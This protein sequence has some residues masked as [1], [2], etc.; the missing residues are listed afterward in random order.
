MDYRPI[1]AE[2]VVSG[3]LFGL[4]AQGLVNQQRQPLPSLLPELLELGLCICPAS[5]VAR[6][7]AP[8]AI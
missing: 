8:Q 4:I 1:V 6:N 2:Q 7:V 5:A 3:A